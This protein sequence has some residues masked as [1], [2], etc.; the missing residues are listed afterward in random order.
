MSIRTPEIAARYGG[1]D[2][3][4]IADGQPASAALLRSIAVNTNRLVTQGEPFLHLIFD[5]GDHF[6]PPDDTA[7]GLQGFGTPYWTM[8]YPG[9]LVLPKRPGLNFAEGRIIAKLTEDSV[10]W[11]QVGTYASPFR[12]NAIA[13]DAG[14]IEMAGTGDWETYSIS[15]IPI[16]P[17]AFEQV[18]LHLRADPLDDAG[19]TG[20]Y[21]SPNTGTL[22]WL[23]VDRIKSQTAA[24]WN[25]DISGNPSWGTGGHWVDIEDPFGRHIVEPKIV[26]QVFSSNELLVW[27]PTE[28]A[29]LITFLRGATY[30][31]KKLP[32]WRVASAVLYTSDRTP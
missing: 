15:D 30:T 5:S 14:V 13:G 24:T 18:T 27:P 3:T 31:I 20:T 1:L 2:T 10:F 22:E 28:A 6:D 19:D 29:Q 25:T 12:H 17:G 23:L 8:A 11:L 21:G 9:P 7:G 4:S 16:D 26:V 32:E